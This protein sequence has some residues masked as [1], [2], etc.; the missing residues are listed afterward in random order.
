MQTAVSRNFITTGA[1]VALYNRMPQTPSINSEYQ[2]IP[3]LL[4]PEALGEKVTWHQ[5]GV[6][7]SFPVRTAALSRA[8]A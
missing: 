2:T 8:G 6:F 5:L 3:R 4:L 7:R 1:G